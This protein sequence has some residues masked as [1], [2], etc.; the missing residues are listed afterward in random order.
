MA[1]SSPPVPTIGRCAS[2][3]PPRATPVGQPMQQLAGTSHLEFSPDGLRLLTG[4]RDATARL[5]NPLTGEPLSPPL[6]QASTVLTVRFTRDGA[7]FFVRDHLGF[8]FWDTEKAEPVTVHFPEPMGSGLGMDSEPWRAIMS[9]DGTL[10]H[11]GMSMNETVLWTV[12]QPRSPVPPWFP[13]FLE[14]LALMRLDS[15]DSTRISSGEGMLALRERLRAAAADQ[16]A[17][18]VWARR[19][20]GLSGK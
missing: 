17:Y 18:A 6:P 16:D 7:C 19:V 11:L 20:L 2:G 8:R 12:A 14:G 4:S 3:M 15:T 1:A 10:V 13:D 5:W 9:G